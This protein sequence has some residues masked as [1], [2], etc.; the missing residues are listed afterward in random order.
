M[1]EWVNTKEHYKW[2]QQLSIPFQAKDFVSSQH[3]DKSTMEKALMEMQT[4]LKKNDFN[5]RFFMRNKWLIYSV[6]RTRMCDM[7]GTFDCK[8]E[9]DAEKC[10]YSHRINPYQSR[11]QR[12]VFS[13]WNLD[14]V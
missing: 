3:G 13:T 6:D 5:G 12:I 8:G 11:E 14:H 9:F 7:F 10:Y 1:L 4:A 2:F